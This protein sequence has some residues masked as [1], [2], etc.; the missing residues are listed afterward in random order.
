MLNPQQWDDIHSMVQFMKAG[1]GGS[2][3]GG[4]PLIGHATIRETVDLERYERER[5]FRERRVMV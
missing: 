5:A 1:Y 2:S 3:G 4:A